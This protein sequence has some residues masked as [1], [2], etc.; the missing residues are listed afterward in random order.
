MI[1]YKYLRLMMIMVVYLWAADNSDEPV[2]SRQ[3]GVNQPI[4]VSPTRIT[5]SGC[6][7]FPFL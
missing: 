4:M 7:L 1:S 3:Q 6:A 5:K 2:R